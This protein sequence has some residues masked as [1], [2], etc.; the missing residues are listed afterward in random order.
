VP[1]MGMN[2]PFER[3]WLEAVT[4]T[5]EKDKA[6]TA[7]SSAER[8]LKQRHG[9][10]NTNRQRGRVRAMSMLGNA[11]SKSHRKTH[12]VESDD[13]GRKFIHLTR[14]GLRR[15]SAGG[16]SRGRSS[17][18][19]CR[20]TGGA[21]GR[22]TK[23]ELPIAYLCSVRRVEVRNAGAQQSRQPPR[24]FSPRRIPG[25]NRERVDTPQVDRTS[26]KEMADGA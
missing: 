13:T 7:R 10:R 8:S 23:R 14:G 3:K 16:V 9:R 25:W 26:E 4:A 6:G 22:R 21:K 11:K 20:K 15:E 1:G 2:L 18:E 19:T 24:R 5:I 12:Q 17:E